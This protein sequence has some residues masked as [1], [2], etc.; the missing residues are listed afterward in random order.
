MRAAFDAL[1]PLMNPVHEPADERDDDGARLRFVNEIRRLAH[2]PRTQ[3]LV[4][5]YADQLLTANFLIREA[6]EAAGT[7]RP[8][9]ATVLS[10][11]SDFW[12]R[13]MYHAFFYRGVNESS[14]PKAAKYAPD[15]GLTVEEANAR[16]VRVNGAL[17]QYLALDHA[18]GAYEVIDAITR[19]LVQ[20]FGASSPDRIRNHIRLLITV[21][22]TVASY[23]Q[24]ARSARPLAH[25]GEIDSELVFARA[26]Q[27]LRELIPRSILGTFSAV[28]YRKAAER[29]GYEIDYLVMDTTPRLMLYRLHEIG[30]ANVLLTSATS[31]L[32]LSTEYH[33]AIKPDYVLAPRANEIG[34]VQLYLFPKR[35]P[36]TGKSLRFSGGGQ[37][38]EDNLRQMVSALAQRDSDNLS[39]L[40]KA[41]RS[42]TTELGRSR[43]VALVVN[44]YEQVQLVVEQ[45]ND[46]NHALGTRTRGVV[47]AMPTG[48]SRARYVLRGQIEELGRDDEVDV[49]VFPIAAL[50][51]GVNVV[52]RTDDND[53]GKAAIGAVY[54]LTRPH[55]AASDLTLMTSLLARATQ[56]LDAQD[57]SDQSLSQVRQTFDRARFAAYRRIGNLLA[58]PMSASQLDSPTLVNFAAN[59]LVPILQTIGR[60]MRKAMPVDIY[61]VDAAWAPNSAEGRPETDRS[62][63]LVVMRQVLDMCLGHPDADLRDIYKALYGIFQDAFRNIDGLLPPGSGVHTPDVQFEPTSAT[64]EIDLDNYDPDV[65]LVN[66]Q[67]D[68]GE[69]EQDDAP[70]EDEEVYE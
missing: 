14:W 16:W 60:G 9:S 48:M 39:D 40:E 7:G 38:R 67:A 33:V 54:F 21:G 43:K 52:F 63:M 45:L 32:E 65:Q 1:G 30:R 55:P 23:Q 20:L 64:A 15:L 69:T 18:A 17:K 2:D 51:R 26:S 11:I 10:A 19:E 53:T 47:K 8:L 56:E 12:E 5:E 70:Y 3:F 68:T 44:S 6:Q 37:D 59:L 41:I 50:G 36:S 28:R 13:A 4:K 27:E 42:I 22:F 61:F 62:S 31:W 57:L 66:G 34:T 35:H 49:I 24:L 29:E 46:V 58:R 25:R